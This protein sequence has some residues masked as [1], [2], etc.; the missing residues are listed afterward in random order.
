MYAALSFAVS[1][2]SPLDLS[3]VRKYLRILPYFLQ[4]GFR[5]D[6]AS[7]ADAAGLE[8][9]AAAFAVWAGGAYDGESEHG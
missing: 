1:V 6:M 3:A 4:L 8:A 7:L 2:D 5:W 9:S